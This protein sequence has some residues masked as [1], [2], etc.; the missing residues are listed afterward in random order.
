VRMCRRVY[1]MVKEI[2]MLILIRALPITLKG[3]V[4]NTETDNISIHS[5]GHTDWHVSSS[6]EITSSIP[7]SSQQIK[8]SGINPLNPELNPI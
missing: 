3:T 8:R 4:V 2:K 1:M 7:N 6:K 5:Q